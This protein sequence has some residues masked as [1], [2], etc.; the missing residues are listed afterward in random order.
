MISTRPYLSPRTRIV[1]SLGPM[2]ATTRDDNRHGG[3]V[4]D[5]ARLDAHH[6]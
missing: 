5:D 1:M 2:R 4:A 6:A 3:G